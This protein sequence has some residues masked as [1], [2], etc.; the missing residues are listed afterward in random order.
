[1]V[2][3]APWAGPGIARG[4]RT[5]V[6]VSLIDTYP[7]LA[8][9][10]RLPKPHQKLEGQSLVS[11]LAKPSTAE[12]RDVFLPHMVPVSTPSL[13]ATGVT[14]ATAKMAKRKS[15]ADR[16]N[17]LTSQ[18]PSGRSCMVIGRIELR[19]RRSGGANVR[20]GARPDGTLPEPHKF[21]Y[22]CRRW[23]VVGESGRNRTCEGPP[24]ASFGL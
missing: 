23:L 6:T 18:L 9:L 17:G 14:S 20:R 19:H 2:P 21:P 8:E 16:R 3:N 1:M 7:T 10:C 11:T 15:L 22:V 13:T 24:Q 12:D 5:D 4:A